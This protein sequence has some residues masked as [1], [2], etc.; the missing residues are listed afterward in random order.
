M[1]AWI[2]NN[3]ET[4]VGI[5]LGMTTVATAFATFAGG[6]WNSTSVANYSKAIAEINH[7]N[8]SYLEY[9]QSFLQ[10]QL[11]E[12]QMELQQKTDAEIDLASKSIEQ[13]TAVLRKEY[14]ESGAESIQ[15]M[16]KADS[17]NNANDKFALA[18]ALYAI[19]LFLGSM[20][21]LVQSRKSKIFYSMLAICLFIGVF[22]WMLF[23]PMPSL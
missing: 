7:A 17:A 10:Q 9:S 5:L 8:T 13:E 23:L 15:L 4:I 14:E 12:L 3:R 20:S 21:L 18:S 6:L 22:T 19:V 1:R 16:E 2:E 11:L